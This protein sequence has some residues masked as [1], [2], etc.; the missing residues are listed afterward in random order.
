[1]TAIPESLSEVFRRWE[2]AD[3]PS[4]P[5]FRWQPASWTNR[6]QRVDAPA[7]AG[8][9][10]VEAVDTIAKTAASVANGDRERIDRELVTK[11][12]RPETL[13]PVGGTWDRQAV[14]TAFLAAMIWGYGTSGYG[15]YRT[16]RVLKSDPHAVEHL[17]D[18]AQTAQ[19]SNG[20]LKAFEE[21]ATAKGA[22]YL[23]YLGPAFGTKYLYFLTAAS[24]DVETT[25]VMDA[26]VRRWFR[27]EPGISLKT[28]TWHVPSYRTYLRY[29]DAWKDLLPAG[30]NGEPLTREDVELLIFASARGDD[31]TWENPG[32]SPTV[33]ELLDLLQSDI[34][35]L[36]DSSGST[37]GPEL[38]NQ[39]TDWVN[40]IDPTMPK[41]VDRSVHL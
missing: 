13:R 36:A 9:N 22:S 38:L 23:K 33:E 12:H 5:R 30:R 25:P 11:L 34:D 6:F 15:P 16:A 3:F 40:G 4:Q 31:I 41:M 7:I 8:I 29:L 24:E 2:R 21:I 35:Q 27:S 1:M 28:G 20:G 32:E 26:V 17:A 19:V 39:L 18:I 10:L 37:K 14:V